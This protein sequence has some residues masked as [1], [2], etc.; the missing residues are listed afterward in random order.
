MKIS[1]C[2]LLLIC[3]V[4]AA[5]A[6]VAPPII[7]QT[8]N[9][10]PLTSIGARFDQ[11]KQRIEYTLRNDGLRTIV[12]WS[13]E[14]TQTFADG[15]T[16]TTFRCADAWADAAGIVLPES[17]SSHL[18]ELLLTFEEARRGTTNP[19]QAMRDA[20]QALASETRPHLFKS[21]ARHSLAASLSLAEQAREDP[22]P[23][24]DALIENT[25]LRKNSIQRFAKAT[26]VNGQLVRKE[27]IQ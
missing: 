9:A 15:T 24:F 10:L 20:I 21:A 23:A 27:A 12:A 6:D 16:E 13:V 1:A 25:R 19:Q 17:R 14:V 7:G 11:G 2:S 22:A 5:N 8:A 3:S 18:D 4:T 26:L